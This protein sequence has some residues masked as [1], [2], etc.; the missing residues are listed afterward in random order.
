MKGSRQFCWSVV[1]RTLYVSPKTQVD[2]STVPSS[3]DTSV[4]VSPP[5][6]DEAALYVHWP[7]CLRRCSYCNFNKY[8]PRSVSHSAMRECLQ[9]E[10]ETLLNLSQVFRITSVFFGGGTPSLAQPATIAAVL[11]TISQHAQLSKGAEVTLEVNPTPAGMSKLKDFVQAGINR[12]SI[13]VQSLNDEDLT[14]LG[15]DHSSQHALHTISEARRLCPGRV[16][17]DVMFGRPGQSVASWEKELEELLCVCD[18]HVSLYQ[19]TLERG[20]QLF[21]QVERGELTVPGEDITAAMYRSAREVLEKRG[22]RQYEVSNFARGGAVSE[23]N[24]GYWRAQ[25]YIGVGPGAHGRFVPLSAGADQR[26]ART[27]TLEPD[28][29]MSEVQKSGH[30]TRRRLPLNRLELLEEVLVMGLRMVDGITHQHWEMFSPSDD[31]H[32]FF[33]QPGDVQELQQRGLLIL[34]D[35]GLRCSWEGLALLDSMLPTLLVQLETHVLRK[36]QQRNQICPPS[37]HRE[38]RQ[39]R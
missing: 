37:Q 11:E 8:I 15:R 27:Q 2:T 20:T 7:Y 14:V 34:D 24:L 9:K 12:L 22:Y 1:K 3:R 25:Q 26:E 39:A 21:K 29:W 35:R 16:S 6:S 17:V 23:H 30:A 28:V 32:A 33:G 13:G 4:L 5:Q 36:G 38:G 18:D 10:T 31:L 19:L